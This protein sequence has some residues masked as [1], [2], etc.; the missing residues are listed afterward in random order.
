MWAKFRYKSF[1]NSELS[2]DK[3]SF[4]LS[5][6]KAGYVSCASMSRN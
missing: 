5:I 4:R 6:L 2:K 3:E 1:E